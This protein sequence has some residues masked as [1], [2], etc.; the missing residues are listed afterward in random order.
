MRGLLS[1]LLFVI[2]TLESETRSLD[3]LNQDL[4]RWLAHD[5]RQFI[6]DAGEYTRVCYLDVRRLI[7]A[8][9]VPNT[10]RAASDRVLFIVFIVFFCNC[11]ILCARHPNLAH[12]L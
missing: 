6:G 11:Q 7:L 9:S 4:D 2:V 5:G 12:L 1:F 3:H 8:A 10:Y